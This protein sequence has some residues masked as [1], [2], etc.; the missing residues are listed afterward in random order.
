MKDIVPNLI[1]YS[2][3]TLLLIVSNPVDI[4]TY[5]AWKVSGLHHSRV[6]GTGTSLD[7]ARFKFFIGQKLG[8][9]PTS[10]HAWIIGEHGDSSGK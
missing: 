7:S 8:V 4:M 5:V 9:P 3:D 2:P 6:F 10:V 1:K